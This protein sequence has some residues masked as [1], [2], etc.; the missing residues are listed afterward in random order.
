MGD[1]NPRP[2]RGPNR[3]MGDICCVFATRSQSDRRKS[4]RY[5]MPT[6]LHVASKLGHRLTPGLYFCRRISMSLL[7]KKKSNK[8]SRDAERKSP[9]SLSD[10]TGRNFESPGLIGDSTWKGLGCLL[11]F[12]GDQSYAYLKLTSEAPSAHTDLSRAR[13]PPSLVS[14]GV[15]L[16]LQPKA[17]FLH[18]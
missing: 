3:E 4:Q 10:L 16:Q 8:T 5:Q 11:L 2:E 14:I 17:K 6:H 15:C 9:R 1:S 18:N 13:L 12:R 7:P